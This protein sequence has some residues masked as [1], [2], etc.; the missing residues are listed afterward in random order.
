MAHGHQVRALAT[1]SDSA[2]RLRS[3]GAEPVSVSLFDRA[4]L[5]AAVT[6]VQAILHLATRIAPTSTARRRAAWQENDRIR[7]EGTRNLVE[8]A[9]AASVGAVVNPSFASIYAD[10]G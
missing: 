8:S 3:A 5:A 9:L 10:G 7:A 1:N 6:G 4:R 2:A